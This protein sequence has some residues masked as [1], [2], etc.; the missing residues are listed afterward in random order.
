VPCAGATHRLCLGGRG[1]FSSGNWLH[2]IRLRL[3]R[4]EHGVSVA[5]RRC[6]LCGVGKHPRLAFCR[7]L[8]GTATP[9]AQQARS[10][11]RLAQKAEN[12]RLLIRAKGNLQ[13]DVTHNTTICTIWFSSYRPIPGIQSSTRPSALSATVP[14]TPIAAHITRTNTPHYRCP[15]QWYHLQ[16]RKALRAEATQTVLTTTTV[17]QTRLE[18]SAS[19]TWKPECSEPET[20][21]CQPAQRMWSSPSPPAPRACPRASGSPPPSA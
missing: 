18:L 6:C 21:R 2:L 11:L 4:V 9:K 13:L 8:T 1:F 5:T 16:R 19:P 17:R 3:G 12:G 7:I 10:A 14:I 20:S 15:R